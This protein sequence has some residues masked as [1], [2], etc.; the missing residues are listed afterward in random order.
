[1]S[2][3]AEGPRLAYSRAEAAQVLGGISLAKVD[4][5]IRTGQLRAKRNG[6]DVLIPAR[7]LEEYLDALPDA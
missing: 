7:A 6:R 2:A 4:Q 5:A 3:T 1:M